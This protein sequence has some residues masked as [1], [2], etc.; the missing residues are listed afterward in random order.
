MRF[1]FLPI[2]LLCS[3]PALCTPADSIIIKGRILNL[4]GRLYRQAPSITFS[5][6]NILQPQSELSR[7]APLQADGTFRISL[8]MLFAKEEFYLDYGGR[9]ATAFL[10][11]PGTLEVTFDGD[12]LGKPSRLFIFSGVNADANNQ[13]FAYLTAENK[14]AQSTKP[15]PGSSAEN[16]KATL[17]PQFFKYFWQ[18]D[19]Q[20]AISAVATRAKLKNMPLNDV[21]N[22]GT[23]SPDLKQWIESLTADESLQLLYEHA[24]SGRYDPSKN[25]L[26]SLQRLR[27]APLTSQRVL[28]ASRFGEYADY[29]VQEIKYTNPARTNSLP[30]KL[31]ASLI[32]DYSPG[33]S[34][35]DRSFLDEVNLKGVTEKT[36]LDNLNK[37]FAKN[38]TTLNLLFNY[39]REA[40][41]YGELFEGPGAEFLKARYLARN[42]YKF[43]YRQQSLLNRHVQ[44][45]NAVPAFRESLDELVKLE[46]KDSADIRKMVEFRDV[47]TTPTEVLPDYYLT[48]SRDRGTSWL[49]GILDQYKGRPVYISKWN[50]EDAKSRSEMEFIPALQASVAEDAVFVFVHLAGEEYEV[51]E[52][53]IRQYIVRHKLRGIHMILNAQQSMDLLFRLNPLDYATFALVRRSGKFAEKNASPPSALEKTVSQ[54]NDAARK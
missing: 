19:A 12:S 54:I 45:R 11:S 36:A 14:L 49:N 27:K 48:A 31:M 25:L 28:W 47:K 39:E 16:P 8:P 43:S 18:Q 35:S 17:G 24:L 15:V 22:T 42:L 2:L 40:R 6:N 44:G 20:E 21:A 1:I 50:L 4:S 3:L 52:A 23:L 32:R 37:L 38:E 51:S 5:R 29:K 34:P 26:D 13:Y 10:G 7:Q 46:L 41:I 30:V 9:A 33:L 53:L